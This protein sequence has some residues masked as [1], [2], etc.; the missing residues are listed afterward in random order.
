MVSVGEVRFLPAV[1]RGV[2]TPQV[3]LV[4]HQ[5]GTKVFIVERLEVVDSV[6]ILSGDVLGIVGQIKTAHKPLA[7]CLHELGAIVAVKLVFA[8]KADESI[9]V[10][11]IYEAQA[12][13]F[14]AGMKIANVAILV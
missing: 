1:V 3:V 11:R 9:D 12:W 6:E 5:H 13:C 10:V 14:A 7:W 4:G 8:Y 2:R